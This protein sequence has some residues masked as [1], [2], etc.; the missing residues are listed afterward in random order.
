MSERSANLSC[1]KEALGVVVGRGGAGG[2]QGLEKG[3]DVTSGDPLEC[4]TRYRSLA[5]VDKLHG[6][7]SQFVCLAC[8]HRALSLIPRIH[9]KTKQG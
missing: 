5:A 1:R 9:V 8:K 3:L 2:G 6:L 4:E 7:G